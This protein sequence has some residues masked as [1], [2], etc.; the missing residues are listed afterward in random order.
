MAKYVHPDALDS[1]LAYIAANCNTLVAIIA[2]TAGDAYATVTAGAN[3][4]ASVALTPVAFA[5][6]NSGLNRVLTYAGNH[7]DASANNT[8]NPT[9]FAFLDSVTSKVLCVTEEN[10]AQTVTSVNPARFPSL[11]YTAAQPT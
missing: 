3:V 7:E 8:G 2:Y 5:L 6:S 1:G 9:H 11:T 10:S 4:I